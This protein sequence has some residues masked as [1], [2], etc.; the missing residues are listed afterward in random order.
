MNGVNNLRDV[1][2]YIEV[3]ITDN[4]NKTHYIL[5][6]SMIHNYFL[7][8]EGIDFG[9][10]YNILK[11][12]NLIITELID[13][14][15]GELRDDWLKMRSLIVPALIEKDEELIDVDR[16]FS[17]RTK[18]ENKN[19]NEDEDKYKYKLPIFRQNSSE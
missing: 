15:N 10:R 6:I 1:L 9:I 2:D 19:E 11:Q 13:H 8:L 17:Y 7:N 18:S 14:E 5:Y 16:Y 4:N 3:G 12:A